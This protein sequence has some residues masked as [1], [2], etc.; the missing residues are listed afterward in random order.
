MREVAEECGVRCELEEELP[1]SHYRVGGRPKHVRWWRMRVVEEL[2]PE[3]RDDEVD[4]LRWVTP[5]EAGRVLSY[6][7]DRSLVTL[8]LK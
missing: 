5:T 8:A 2:G 3:A 6:E 4:E 1:P 7:P